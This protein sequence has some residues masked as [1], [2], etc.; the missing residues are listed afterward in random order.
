MAYGVN[1]LARME[2]LLSFFHVVAGKAI[3]FR[4][5]DW[6]DFKSCG[7]TA[8]PAATDCAI[9]TGTGALAAFQLVKTYTQGS[10]HPQPQDPEA[11]RGD[12]ARRG[13]R[14]RQDRHD[15]HYTLDDT[16]GI[17]TF[18]AGNIP[19]AGQAVT[20]GF[21]FDVPVR[22][23]TDRLSVNINDYNCRRDPGAA[24]RAEIRGYLMP[25]TI[26]AALQTHLEGELTTLAMCWRIL[27]RR[28]GG[29]GLDGPRRGDRLRRGRLHPARER[30]ALATTAR[31][32]A[33]PRPTWTSRWPSPPAAGT[34][35]E[36][37]AGLYDYAEV[38][39][40]PDQL[41]RHRAWASSSSPR[42]PGRGR[43]PRQ[44][45]AHRDALADP[46]TGDHHRPHLHPGVRR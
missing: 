22:F 32:R 10:L 31:R 5:K 16:T 2:N 7:R 29:Q 3:G 36:L 44:P 17:V 33:S 4:Y 41:G 1:T 34:D 25:R 14:I 18:T 24:D 45:G 20:A 6:L 39:T 21:E 13:R 38:W 28:R 42:A 9:G 30:P 23:D 43:D 12:G 37:R 35:A 11:D 26:S 40:L 19:T 15:A 46:A 27:R 8:T